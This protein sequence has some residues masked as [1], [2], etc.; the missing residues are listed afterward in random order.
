MRLLV[1]LYS[2]QQG[3]KPCQL[4]FLL[5]AAS[6]PLGYLSYILIIYVGYS[7]VYLQDVSLQTYVS[8]ICLMQTTC[9]YSVRQHQVC[10]KRKLVSACVL[11]SR[12]SM[13]NVKTSVRVSIRFLKYT[14]DKPPIKYLNGDIC[15]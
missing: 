4:T 11:L 13:F 1:F 3:R 2:T 5:P 7:V 6:Y 12:S 10:K 14:I 9:V 15:N 8:I